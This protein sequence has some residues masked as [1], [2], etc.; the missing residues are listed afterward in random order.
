MWHHLFVLND[1]VFI[2]CLSCFLQRVFCSAQSLDPCQW[3]N[4]NGDEEGTFRGTVLAEGGHSRSASYHTYKDLKCAYPRRV[5]PHKAPGGALPCCW[6][7][8]CT[9]PSLLQDCSPQ[10]AQKTHR[11][12]EVSIHHY[13]YVHQIPVIWVIP[14]D[15]RTHSM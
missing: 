11:V 9:A 3:M 13:I 12:R 1:D 6:G 8:C 7:T 4:D 15:T 2:L 5:Q 14:C 10:K